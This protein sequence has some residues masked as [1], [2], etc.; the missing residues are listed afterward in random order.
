M[1]P[2]QGLR[3]IEL[4]CIGPGPFAGMLLSD[5][6]AEILRIDRPQE[7]PLG[8]PDYK[9]RTLWRN[10][11]AVSLDLSKPAGVEALLQLVEKADGLIEGYRPGVAERLGVGPDVCLKRNPRLVYGRMTG[12]GQEGPLAK[13]AGFDINYISLTGLLHAIGPAEHPVP[14]LIT[15][16]DFGGGGVFLALGML[17]AFWE[18]QRSGKG[19][20]VDASIVDGAANLMAY[21][22][23]GL[24]GGAWQNRRASNTVDGGHWRYG[25]YECSDGRFVSVAA[26]MDPF[27]KVLLEK[28]GLNA[29]DFPEPNKRSNWPAYREKLAVIF[30][31]KPRDEWAALFAGTDGCV[32]P[33]LDLEEAPQH[34]HNR[35][36]ETF[37]EHGGVMQPAPAPR[38]SRTRS[39]IRR[40]PP[41]NGQD[42]DSAL[43]EW[44]LSTEAV[45]DLRKRGAF[46]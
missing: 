16:G 7:P 15:A 11:Q 35:A 25:V 2:L 14:P 26:M 37:V 17:A 4:F 12:W 31:T 9:Y 33:V 20:V 32:V 22:Y 10:R 39:E 1:G 13:Q 27:L 42:N 44:G 5:M 38:F 24:A 34:P 36:R 41:A 21:V 28:L 30:R 6:G 43:Q 3:I 8:Y 18:A 45:D 23:G 19:Q 46:G 40:R 29:S